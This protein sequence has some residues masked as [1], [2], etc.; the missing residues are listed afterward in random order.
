MNDWI[1]GAVYVLGAVIALWSLVLVVRDELAQDR[2]FALLAIAEVVLLVQLVVGCIL[3]AGTDRDVSGVLFVSYLV[4]IALALPIGAFWSLA[5]R[6][7]SGT[8]VLAI[9][10][11]T[12]LA[13][14]VRL[15]DIWSG[16]FG[17]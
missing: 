3:L 4:G 13:L 17:A 2:T 7:R 1:T 11:L 5:E 9:A 14:E 10:A 8:G 6:T 15:A 16:G 12:V